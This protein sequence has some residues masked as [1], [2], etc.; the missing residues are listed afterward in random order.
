MLKKLSLTLK[1]ISLSL[2]AKINTAN[3]EVMGLT[4]VG[5][6]AVHLWLH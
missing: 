5:D 2:K 6:H 4:V 3:M 1:R